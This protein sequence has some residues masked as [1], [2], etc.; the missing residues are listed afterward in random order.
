MKQTTRTHRKGLTSG[1]HVTQTS[2]RT[3]VFCNR[4][5]TCR[6]VEKLL[7]QAAKGAK[8]RRNE[9]AE[10]QF[11]GSSARRNWGVNPAD[12]DGELISDFENSFSVQS[13]LRALLK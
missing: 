4:I 3:I 1:V 11:G 6:K 2:A 12:L 5:S 10:D 13:I 8:Q 9:E 7:L